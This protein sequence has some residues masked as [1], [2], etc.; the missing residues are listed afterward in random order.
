MSFLADFT[1]ELAWAFVGLVAGTVAHEAG[2][3]AAAALVSL[4][5]LRVR[6]GNGAVVKRARLG[7]I[8]LEFR[9]VPVGGFVWIKADRS[10]PRLRLVAFMLGGGAVNAAL[11]GITVWLWHSAALPRSSEMSLLGFGMAQLALLVITLIPAWG[12]V[13]GIRFANDGMQILLLLRGRHNLDV[14]LTYEDLLAHYAPGRVAR[15]TD[16]SRVLRE[17]IMGGGLWLG[18]DARRR[19][20]GVVQAELGA[21]VMSSGERLLILDLLITTAL[22]SRDLVFYGHLDDWARQMSEL[23]PAD[24]LTTSTRGVVLVERGDFAAGKALLD[25]VAKPSFTPS[26]PFDTSDYIMVQAF[27]ARAEGALGNPRAGRRRLVDVRRAISSNSAYESL[28]PLVDRIDRELLA[29]RYESPAATGILAS[30]PA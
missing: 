29:G 8:E 4:P 26:D 1:T 2:H 16:A 11:L 18:E 15:M 30:A 27:I 10:T 13:F 14:H 22:I 12:R 24:A 7:T 21:T 23:D 9:L 20:L 28:R 25:K 3:C 5:I 17:Q 19:V 6:I